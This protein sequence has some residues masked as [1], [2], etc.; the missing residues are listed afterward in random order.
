MG[1]FAAYLRDKIPGFNYYQVNKVSGL[2]FTILELKENF[3][4]L[5]E[6]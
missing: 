5:L 6:E 4:K 3:E 2:P 1:Q